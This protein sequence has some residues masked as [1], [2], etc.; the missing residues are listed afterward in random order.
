MSPG[1]ALAREAT[2]QVFMVSA[3]D[4]TDWKSPGEE[5]GGSEVIRKN[6]GGPA[7]P[8]EKAQ[9]SGGLRSGRLRIGQKNQAESRQVSVRPGTERQGVA[10]RETAGPGTGSQGKA[11]YVKQQ[12]V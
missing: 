12:E 6:P 8:K 9:G 2:V 7:G 10:P 4:F 1:R 11:E 3:M 5:T